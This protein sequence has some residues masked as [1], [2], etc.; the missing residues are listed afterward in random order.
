M[1]ELWDVLEK[2]A[3]MV[4]LCSG[5]RNSRIGTAEK[6]IAV[7]M[8]CKVAARSIC[9]RIRYTLWGTAMNRMERWL[10]RGIGEEWLQNFPT[11]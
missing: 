10:L 2:T 3:E 4:R 5:M 6:G 1:A 7:G 9:L 8:N 11:I